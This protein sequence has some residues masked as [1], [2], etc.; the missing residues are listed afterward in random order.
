MRRW[1]DVFN[2]RSA[3]RT[4]SF[5]LLRQKKQNQRKGDP[6]I[7]VGYADALAADNRQGGGL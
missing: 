5:L 3:A 1:R 2:A 7:C 4:G 6:G